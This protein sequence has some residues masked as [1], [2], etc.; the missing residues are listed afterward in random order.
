MKRRKNHLYTGKLRRRSLFRSFPPPLLYSPHPA[1]LLPPSILLSSPPPPPS[2]SSSSFIL[3]TPPP[4]SPP[5]ILLSYSPHPAPLLP[6]SILLS[7]PSFVF[8][9]LLYSPHPAPLLPPPSILLSSPLLRFHPPPLFS[10]PRPPPPSPLSFF[11]PPSFVFILLLY[12][13]HSAPLLPPPLS[14]FPPPLLRFHPPPLFSSPRPPPPP[15][16]SILLSS[17][18][19]RFHPPPLFSSPRPPPP[20]PLYPSTGVPLFPLTPFTPKSKKYILPTVYAVEEDI[21]GVEWTRSSEGV[22]DGEEK[23]NP[24]ISTNEDV[25]AC[26]EASPHPL[27]FV[28]IHLLILFTPP[29]LSLSFYRSLPSPLKNLKAV[30]DC[31]CPSICSWKRLC[32]WSWFRKRGGILIM[33]GISPNLV[34]SGFTR[35]RRRYRS[36]GAHGPQGELLHPESSILDRLPFGRLKEILPHKTGALHYLSATC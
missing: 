33:R 18:L 12:S 19:L 21:E 7:S 1:P 10:S 5:S 6:P 30:D 20:S 32:T 8:I 36:G 2:F 31:Y 28:F 22:E 16:P 26:F 4:S 35:K 29:P 15:P 17:P 14:F 9:L 24:L 11:P 3:L 34:S 13:P 23:K 25:E 27:F